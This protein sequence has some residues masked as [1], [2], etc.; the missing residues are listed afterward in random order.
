[1]SS[2]SAT[3]K[4]PNDLTKCKAKKR[5]AKFNPFSAISVDIGE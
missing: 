2:V 1:M 5:N 4:I 3:E